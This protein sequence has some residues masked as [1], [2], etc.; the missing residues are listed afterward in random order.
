[1]KYQLFHLPTGRAADVE[2]TPHETLLI[3]L[4]RVTY[5]EEPK[6][7]D[8]SSRVALALIEG[9]EASFIT[10]GDWRIVKRTVN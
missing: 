8:H 1:M 9:S 7:P 3:A 2:V 6:Y 5:A 10:V 4:S